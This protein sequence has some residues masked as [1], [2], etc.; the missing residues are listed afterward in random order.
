MN[1]LAFDLSTS[2][3]NIAVSSADNIL[4]TKT[5]ASMRHS[6]LV[7]D[8]IDSLLKKALLKPRDLQGILCTGGPGSFTGLRMGYSIAK[9][10]SLCLSVPFSPVPTLDCI[11][12]AVIADNNAKSAENIIIPVISARKNTFFY[13]VF[14]S[15]KRLKEDRET[16]ASEISEEI[17]PFISGNKT[18]IITGHAARLLYDS[19]HEKTESIFIINTEDAC[20]A[21]EAITIAQK[22]KLMDNNNTAYLFSGPEYLRLPDAELRKSV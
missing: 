13:T 15:E 4:Y 12:N 6:E 2:L 3:L 8:Q 22:R 19:I 21:K 5:E 18:V 20:Y 17:T 7:M 9:A 16:C 14:Q 10:L 1:L 11:A